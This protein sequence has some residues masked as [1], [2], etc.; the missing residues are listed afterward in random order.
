MEETKEDMKIRA[1]EGSKKWDYWT[2]RS[3]CAGNCKGMLKKALKVT[4]NQILEPEFDF[5]MKNL[6]EQEVKVFQENKT[7]AGYGM[8]KS[9]PILILF[10]KEEEV[11]Q[12][13][14][15]SYS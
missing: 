12:D 8:N 11:L 4:F 15:N 5:I 6:M 13:I 14:L 3:K 10:M 2:Y 7:F 9:N 1:G